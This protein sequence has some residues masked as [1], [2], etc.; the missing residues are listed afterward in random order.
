MEQP[1]WTYR[2]DQDI[3]SMAHVLTWV[4]DDILFL[5]HALLSVKRGSDGFPVSIDRISPDRYTITNGSILVDEKPVDA[6][7]VIFV[8]GL[9]DGL[10]DIGARSIRG[11]RYVEEAWVGRVRNPIPQTVIKETTDQTNISDERAEGIVRQ[12]NEKRRDPDGATTYVPY[13][14]AVEALGA[15]DSNL[16]VEARNALRIDIG[17]FVGV[18]STLM[19]ATTVQASLTYENKAG[20]RD[21][22]YVEALPLYAAAIEQ[23]LSLDDVVPRGQRVRF[24]FSELYAQ[25]PTPTGAPTED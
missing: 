22:F 24:D 15:N 23:R 2:S 5:G 10:L 11:A 13:G 17:S 9:V 14:L 1:T 6:R 3:V 16:F 20:E 8:P 25:V 12:F 21:R 19:D 18:P 7:D 4:A